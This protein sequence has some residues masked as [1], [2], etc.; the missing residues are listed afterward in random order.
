MAI[1]GNSYGAPSPDFAAYNSNG[2]GEILIT[3]VS[4]TFD[5]LGA[6]FSSFA[7]A[8]AFF[9]PFSAYSVSLVGYVGGVPTFFAE[10]DLSSTGYVSFVAS[11]GT[12][13]GLTALGIFSGNDIIANS[14]FFGTDGQS[15][16]V[17]NV[18][19]MLNPAAVPEP[20]T[21]LL[22]LAGLVALA[23]NPK[24]RRA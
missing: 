15:F 16:L 21:A 6:D 22:L 13:T 7:F 4:G 12:F 17:D 20:G 19:V 24:R 11:T 1:Y 5:F 3:P 14:P 10:F 18:T 23:R 8:D 2:F 9:D